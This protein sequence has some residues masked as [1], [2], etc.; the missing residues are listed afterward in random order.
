MMTVEAAGAALHDGNIVQA[1]LAARAALVVGDAI[2]RSHAVSLR[3]AGPDTE[4]G[5]W[6][7]TRLSQELAAARTTLRSVLNGEVALDYP[8]RLAEALQLCR[9]WRELDAEFALNES[10]I[11]RELRERHGIV[12]PIPQ[13]EVK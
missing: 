11:V 12:L 5:A 7:R 3:D 6:I 13:P 2:A 9:I 10:L 1:A 4:Q 8:D